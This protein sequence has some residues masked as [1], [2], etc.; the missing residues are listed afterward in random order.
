MIAKRKRDGVYYTPQWVADYLAEQTLGPWFEEAKTRCGWPS[1]ECSA[2]SR[3]QLSAYE[4]A[5]RQIRI[6]DPACGS[7]VLLVAAFRRL[8]AERSAIER[9]R[10]RL[11]GGDVCERVDEA[12]LASDI[13]AS[14]IFGVDIDPTAVELA[15]LA[16]SL[17]ADAPPSAL[18]GAIHCGNSLVT[19][20]FWAGRARD[21]D[22]MDRVN[23]FDWR[24]AFPEVWPDGADR[25][26]DIVLGNP[27]YV[28]LQTL[29]AVDPEVAAWLQAAR[30]PD[31]YE[32]ARTGNFDLYLPFIEQGLRLLA[33]HGRMAYI[34]PSLWTMNRSGKGLRRLVRAQQ[35]LERWVDLG[36]FQVFGEAATYTALQVFRRDGAQAIR[37]A[38]APGGAAADV[39]WSSADLEV[40]YDAFDPDREWLMV[41]GPERTLIDR[42]AASCPRLDDPSVTKGIIV[43]L[44]TSADAVYH[45]TRVAKGRYRCKPAGAPAYGVEIEDEI[46]KPLVSGEAAKR[47][48][49][50]QTNIW[51]LFPYERTASGAMQLIPQAGMER[52]FPR[53]WAHLRSCEAPLRGRERGRFDDA[54]WWRFGRHQNLDKQDIPKLLVPRLVKRLRT[55]FDAA[56]RYYLDNVDVGGVMP[57]QGVDGMYL[58]AVLNGPLADFVFRRISKPF[59]NDF[60]SANRQFIAPLPVPNASPEAQT[61]IADLA[62][63]LEAGWT[64]RRTLANAA[65]E[66]RGTLDAELAA[67]ETAVNDHLNALY[68]LTSAERL[69]VENG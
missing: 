4:A 17:H 49:A 2:P 51:L 34:A 15:K 19:P 16:L 25:G 53:A 28:K 9:E 59:Q 30:G 21:P 47:Y 46:M 23:A 6:V 33:P 31:T 48:A 22:R 7:G 38:A 60:R 61:A 39:D 8:L 5:V 69:L 63:R 55:S 45:L 52:R 1:A 44:Q 64:R 3:E 54:A 29:R 65:D 43:G 68:G 18:D 12:R 56:G 67:L 13:L 35:S 58:A 62:R 14:N 66:R 36:S 40:A 10:V 32:S 57:A 37:I 11:A 27:P 26:F 41:A 24:A 50:P 42:L 20:D